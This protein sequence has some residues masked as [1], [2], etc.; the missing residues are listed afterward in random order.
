MAEGQDAHKATRLTHVDDRGAAHMVDVGE[1]AITRRTARAGCRVRMAKSTMDLLVAQALPKGDVLA[2]ARIAG[3]MAAKKTSELVP[4]CHPLF[5]THVDVRFAVDEAN[6]AVEIECEA[7]TE[8]RTGVE[9][10]AIVGA[11][12]A[13]V[14]IYDMC[15]AV[16]RG[17]V[18]EDIRLLEKT[19][20]KE[21]YH[22]LELGS[23][24]VV[25]VNVSKNKGERKR[26]V[27]QIWLKVGKGVEGDA[28]AG[29]GER[30]VSLLAKESIDKMA[31]SGLQVGPGDFAENI[32]TEGIDLV[33][34]PVGTLMSIGEAEV[35][36]TQIGKKCHS[37]C[38]IYQ[39]AGDCIMPREGVFAKVLRGGRVAPGDPIRVLSG[40]QSNHL[41]AE[42]HAERAGTSLTHPIRAAVVT[43]SDKASAGLRED[44]SGPLLAQLLQQIGA[45][46]GDPI[47]LPDEPTL[48]EE[49]LAR[50]ADSGQ[51]DL[52]LTTGGTGLGPRDRA[53]EATQAV[54]DRLVPGIS[55]AIRLRSLEHT[56]RA[57]LSRAVAA[58]R[59]RTL[60]INLSGSPRACQEQFAVIAPVL[61]HAV[62]TLR[63]EAYECARS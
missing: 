61:H 53:P 22:R 17:I 45:E 36:I 25:A 16:D 48:I 6:S 28:H 2:V 62:E 41:H 7:R 11:A 39:Q 59:G 4:L 32:T 26:Q 31:A 42:A 23:G 55:E 35:E 21:D 19:G 27:D 52:V 29:S 13:A 60:I 24:R 33:S 18:I 54:A 43:L 57:M 3:I 1:K 44:S 40:G 49:T 12:M 56:S 38:T 47:V 14:T 51:W 46:V 9:M 34:L 8:E 30:E 5:L 50:L 37:R 63:G 20:G 10:E 58:V 15:K